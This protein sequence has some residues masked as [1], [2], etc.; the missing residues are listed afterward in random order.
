M[1]KVVVL[2]P[3]FYPRNG[4]VEKHLKFVSRELISRG[5]RPVI[6]VRWSDYLPEH[7]TVEGVEVWRMPAVLSRRNLLAWIAR[8]PN[9][10]LGAAAVHSHDYYVDF[11]H[12]LMPR[13][14]WVH[15]FH[16]YEG[17]PIRQ[18]SVDAR[19]FVRKCVKF[20]FGVGAYI[21]K[22]YGTKLDAVTYGAVEPWAAEPPAPTYDLVFVGRLEEDTGIMKY[23]EAF[24]RLN[25]TQTGLR[26]LVV[27]Y[28]SLEDSAC[29]YAKVHGLD[30][31][32]TG[33]VVDVMPYAAQ[34]RVMCTGGYLSILEGAITG[35]SM[36][37]Y[38][39][40]PIRE[41]A[42]RC[43]P[44]AKVYHLAGTVDEMVHA[45]KETQKPDEA[46]RVEEARRWAK[47]QTWG[48]LAEE[49][50]AAYEDHERN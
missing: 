8:H 27:G 31:T 24:L 34:G 36:I 17:Y 19:R 21:E 9:V 10:F 49:Y 6:L 5:W 35:R 1:K 18:E 16:G 42:M 32:F 33:E 25:Q 44:L 4:G 30:V 22:W 13:I 37:V 41:D 20:C 47:L 29:E 38:Y 39:E 28:G 11:L 23:L 40:T 7:Q 12:R 2:A 50:I 45:F 46:A 48:K 14:R 3:A 15:T 43:H 26:M